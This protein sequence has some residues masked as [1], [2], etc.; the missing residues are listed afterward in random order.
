MWTLGGLITLA[1]GTLVLGHPF[2]L[3]LRDPAAYLIGLA[4]AT[5]YFAWLLTRAIR[6]G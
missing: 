2:A 4:L 3:W 6:R 5:V 1:A